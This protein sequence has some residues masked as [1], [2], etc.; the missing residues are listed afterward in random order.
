MS[1]MFDHV[2]ADRVSD[3]EMASAD[4]MLEAAIDAG[5]EDVVSTESGHEIY[6]AQATL[7]RGHQGAGSEVRRAA[8]VGADL[9]TA[10]HHGRR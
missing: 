9:E 1:F 4:D 8:Q 7:G 10:E 3:A 2:G 5:A 6:A